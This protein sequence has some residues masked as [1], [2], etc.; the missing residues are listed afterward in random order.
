VKWW[1][2]RWKRKNGIVWKGKVWRKKGLEWGWKT[3]HTP[4]YLSS[5]GKDCRYLSRSVG[6]LAFARFLI[7][8]SYALAH[9]NQ[10]EDWLDTAHMGPEGWRAVWEEIRPQA[11][12][13]KN[14]LRR[15]LS[16]NLLW[17]KLNTSS[18]WLLLLCSGWCRVQILT[19]NGLS[20]DARF[21]LF[22]SVLDANAM[23]ALKTIHK[24]QPTKFK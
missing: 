12:A 19:E 10:R 1:I 17:H 7:R 15:L 14:R 13:R 23:I 16:Q 20:L 4:I 21:V 22:S 2:V 5:L 11:V 8:N 24:T 9:I 18:Y 6:S 3:R